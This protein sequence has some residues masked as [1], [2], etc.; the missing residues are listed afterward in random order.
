MSTFT[1][2]RTM[3]HP[4]D[5]VWSTLADFGGIHRYSGSVEVSPI[6]EGTPDKG[7]GAE[8]RCQLYDG[9]HIQE[10]VTEFT[11]GSRLALEVFDTSLPMK[12]A[13]AR[14]DLQPT[15]DG[16]CELT[17]T[18]EYVVKFGIIGRALDAVMMRKEMIKSLTLLLAG[19]DEYAK[20]GEAIEKGWKPAQ[21][22]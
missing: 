11:E 16:G 5:K 9:N 21:E 17:M 1:V 4:V 8:R 13:A 19:L 7:L 22:S 12:S 3:G 15:P 18:M 14:F 20:T 2:S 6:N 10:R